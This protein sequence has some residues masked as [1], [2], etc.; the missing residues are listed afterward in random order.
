MLIALLRDHIL[1]AIDEVDVKKWSSMRTL[2]LLQTKKWSRPLQLEFAGGTKNGGGSAD[3]G[4][5]SD[6]EMLEMVVR[7]RLQV[8]QQ[9]L[10]AGDFVHA[11]VAFEAA[12]QSTLQ[13]T[14]DDVADMCEE[15][16]SHLRAALAAQAK[17]SK[18]IAPSS[19][20]PNSVDR[21]KHDAHDDETTKI[22]MLS[23]NS[24]STKAA[25]SLETGEQSQHY[26]EY[27]T[28]A[29]VGAKEHI[30]FAELIGSM[31]LQIDSLEA[32]LEIL[33]EENTALRL[34]NIELRQSRNV[35]VPPR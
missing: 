30:V 27:D 15:V 24:Q 9:Q 33:R 32:E 8:G 35:V 28:T 23:T 1:Q 4:E 16:D 11:I 22:D 3:C 7:T 5:L 2:N 10:A 6:R 25:T 20:T 31:R 19:H 29:M 18:V 26:C 14:S 13:S 34:E 12:R 17:A 21:F